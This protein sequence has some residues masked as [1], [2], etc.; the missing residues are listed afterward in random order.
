MSTTILNVYY[1]A[2]GWVYNVGTKKTQLMENGGGGEGRNV[3]SREEGGGTKLVHD[4]G[5]ALFGVSAAVEVSEIL[6]RNPL[7]VG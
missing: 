7:K 4:D 1:R 6:E 5:V 2:Q 3:G